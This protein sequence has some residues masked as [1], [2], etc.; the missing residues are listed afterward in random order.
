MQQI[1]VYGEASKKKLLISTVDESELDES[2]L[3]WLRER[4]IP[5]ASSCN[6]DGVCKKCSINNGIL[7][8]KITIRELIQNNLGLISISYL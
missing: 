4:N 1:V 3:K 2:A 6:G 5:I 8:C 7:S